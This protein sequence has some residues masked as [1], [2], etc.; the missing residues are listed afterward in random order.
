MTANIAFFPVGNGD[1]T[2]IELESGRRILIDV[3]IRQG[4]DDPGDETPN[5]TQELRNRLSRD[6]DGRLFVDALLLS[7]PD[8]DHCRGLR[9]HFHLG[10]PAEWSKSDDKIIVRELWSSPMV[11]RRASSRMTL[12]DDAKAFNTEA[13]RRVRRFREAGHSVSDGDRI[14]I[15]G[16]DENGKTNGLEEILVEEA[17]TFS[18]VNGL[19]DATMV[20]RLLAPM[21]K[22][23]DAE[24]EEKAAKNQSSTILQFQLSGGGSPDRCRFLT[25]GD[26]GVAIW[27]RLW[28]RHASQPEHLSYDVLQAPH[29]CSWR[30]LSHDSWSD[31]GEKAQVSEH[32]RSAL[33]QARPGAVIISSSV[34]IR[35]EDSDPPCTRAKREYEAI[36]KEAGGDEFRCVGEHPSEAHPAVL[37]YE[38]GPYGHTRKAAAVAPAILTDSTAVASEPRGHG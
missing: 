16:R 10:P 9:K 12:C 30:C 33:A 20:A 1:M 15:L 19:D 7:H 25:G 14:L 21:P 26:A 34:P 27:E 29:H 38:I 37:E 6:A 23:D 5:V 3:N 8:A 36:I 31:L 13:R 28:N 11:F 22:S 32:A 17:G 35:D 18:R 4:A 2:L 24:E